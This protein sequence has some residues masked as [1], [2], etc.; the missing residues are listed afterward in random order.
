MDLGPWDIFSLARLHDVVNHCQQKMLAR[1]SWRKAPCLLVLARS[2]AAPCSMS[3]FAG[4]RLP[5]LSWSIPP[6]SPCAQRSPAPQRMDG[7][8]SASSTSPAPQQFPCHTV[9]HSREC[10]LQQ[11]L[12]RVWG[13]AFAS[14]AQ[15]PVAAPYYL[16]SLYSRALLTS[17]QP[18]HHRSNP[19]S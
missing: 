13:V 19:L 12:D 8:F 9:G 18:S 4:T 7:A 14:G 3:S 11:G 10:S 17:Y 15:G 2:L 1:H 6:T 5:L 16:L